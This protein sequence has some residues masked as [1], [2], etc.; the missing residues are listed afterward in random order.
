MDGGQAEDIW[1][2]LRAAIQQIHDHDASSL[3]FEELYR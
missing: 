1:H 2:Q 3:S